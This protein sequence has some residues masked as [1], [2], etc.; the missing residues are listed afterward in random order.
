MLDGEEGIVASPG[1]GLSD[2]LNDLHRLKEGLDAESRLPPSFREFSTRIV[3]LDFVYASGREV[4]RLVLMQL[5]QRVAVILVGL[6]LA[7]ALP[8]RL[9]ALA[10][11]RVAVIRMLA[12]ESWVRLPNDDTGWVRVEVGLKM[13]D[14]D[15]FAR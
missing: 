3:R 12:Q 1:Y 9:A 7:L 5:S 4:V 14:Q 13:A 11:A 6:V 15:L 8:M 2:L 10:A